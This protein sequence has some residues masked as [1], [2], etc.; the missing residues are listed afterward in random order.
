MNLSKA[1]SYKI[2]EQ[3][4][5]YMSTFCS[6]P[7]TLA[8]D[9]NANDVQ[10]T[11]DELAFFDGE[12]V[13]LAVDAAMDVSAETN[14]SV[15]AWANATA[16]SVGN[17]R[18][19]SDAEGT[20]VRLR[21]IAAHTSNAINDEPLVGSRWEEY[22]VR[23]P[24]NAPTAA[25]A[26]VGPGNTRA[27]LFFAKRDGTLVSALCGNDANSTT[28]FTLKVPQYDPYTYVPVG[29]RHVINA[30]PSNTYTHGATAD[31]TNMTIIYSDLTTPLF[32]HIDNIRKK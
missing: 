32:P 13:K 1:F 4:A 14:E 10:T 7:M 24:H 17:I 30:D 9:S 3:M 25:A 27:F 29:F 31:E 8:V 23:E 18:K 28:G 22:W 11:A 2:M 16:Y 20:D 5:R 26:T 15:T 12:M 6:M 19:N 21:C